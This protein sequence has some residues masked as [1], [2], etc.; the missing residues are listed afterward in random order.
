MEMKISYISYLFW[1]ILLSSTLYFMNHILFIANLALKSFNQLKDLSAYVVS[2]L[3]SPEA[4]R[5]ANV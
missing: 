2:L 4:R 3:M 1:W 5:I